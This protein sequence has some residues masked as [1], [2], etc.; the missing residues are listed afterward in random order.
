[1]RPYLILTVCSLASAFAF[2]QPDTPHFKSGAVMYGVV[3]PLFGQPP[4][5]AVTRRLD[6]LRQLGVDIL[7][8]SPIFESDDKSI[9]NYA[10]TDYKRIRPDFGSEDDLR[11]LTHEAH[12]RGMKVIL[13]FVPNHTSAAHPYFLNTQLRGRLSP[14]YSFYER[15]A[16]GA[17]VFYFDWANLVNL[18]Y[19][20]SGV[21]NMMTDAFMY[22]LKQTSIDGYRVD[23]AWGVRDRAPEFWPNLIPKLRHIRPDMLMLAEASPRDPYYLE[24][25]F[26]LAYDWTDKLGHWSWQ[27]AFRDPQ[28]AG[29]KLA[30]ALRLHPRPHQVLRF[31]NNND[32]GPRFVTRY[33]V[34]LN[35][36]AIVFQHTVPGVPLLFTGDEVGAEYS[37]Y[38]DPQPIVWRDPHQLS[39]L[40]RKL[41]NLR[42]T[43]PA[44]HS[45]DLHIP[46][47]KGVNS[48]LAFMR[49]IGE[50]QL[51]ILINFDEAANL[52]VN[53]GTDG[54]L[55][56]T[57]L[58]TGKKVRSRTHGRE[59]L[60]FL[61]SRSAFIL[62]LSRKSTGTF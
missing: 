4:L 29:Q 36:V 33:G 15:D 26:D 50:D 20:H 44:L 40:Y 11:Q 30:A 5:K 52:E 47:Q 31:L 21:V 43:Q 27:E 57:D 16:D 7:W 45:G 55:T 60:F 24:N 1:M 34:A 54:P 6:E 18:N 25:G 61:P 17:P 19:D 51:L 37:P 42:E 59:H 39:S 35:K 13:D 56:F 3:P 12:L 53:L 8:L 14:F 32:T 10:V 48:T 38:D 49:R 41:A 58:L 62:K 46:P 9:L 22:W 23:V 28:T 2:A